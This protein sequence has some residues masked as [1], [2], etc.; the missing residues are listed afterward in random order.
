VLV[1]FA[2]EHY[3]SQ[4]VLPTS[5]RH[6]SVLPRSHKD[7]ARKAFEKVTKKALPGSYTQLQR[8]LSAEAKSYRQRVDALERPNPA[9]RDPAVDADTTPAADVD[10]LVEDNHDGDL[11]DDSDVAA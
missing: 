11:D 6:G 10:E 1:V 8:A 2:A 4:L 3:A 5:K 9:R 7:S